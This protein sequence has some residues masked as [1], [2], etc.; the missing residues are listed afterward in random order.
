MPPSSQGLS[1]FRVAG[2]G[3][4]PRAMWS[5]APLLVQQPPHPGAHPPAPLD[6][7][8]GGTAPRGGD[9]SLMT[10]S[11]WPLGRELDLLVRR[12]RRSRIGS[13]RCGTGGD[14]PPSAMRSPRWRRF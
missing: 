7:R 14:S 8:L 5:S 11:T 3:T 12:R 2:L 1:D 4:P 13:C 9:A 10:C 6:E